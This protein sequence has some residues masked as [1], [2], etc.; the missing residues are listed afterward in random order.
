MCLDVTTFLKPI[1]VDDTNDIAA[2][3]YNVWLSMVKQ[4]SNYIEFRLSVIGG[5]HG[6]LRT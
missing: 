4:V 3:I 6:L 2:S 5:H 1:L